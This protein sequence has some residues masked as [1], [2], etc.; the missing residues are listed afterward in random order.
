M[1]SSTSTGEALSLGSSAVPVG[2]TGAVWTL[3]CTATVMLTSPS[4]EGAK[5]QGFL[6][7]ILQHWSL[8]SGYCTC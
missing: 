5:A 7:L 8:N 4:G 1:K 3:L 6:F 2:W